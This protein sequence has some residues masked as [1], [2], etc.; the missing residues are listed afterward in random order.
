MGEVRQIWDSSK[1]QGSQT[2]FWKFLI[3]CFKQASFGN[4]LKSSIYPYNCHWFSASLSLGVSLVTYLQDEFHLLIAIVDIS[5]TR[6][7]HFSSILYNLYCGNGHRTR[8]TC[9]LL[10]SLLSL[11]SLLW[12]HGCCWS[13]RIPLLCKKFLRSLID[14]P[15]HVGR[16]KS[17][18]AL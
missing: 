7:E 13:E 9:V 10:L 5:H 11:L 2:N 12:R 17:V 15:C 3:D 14:A 16:L 6:A 8:W 1:L 18:H 4:I